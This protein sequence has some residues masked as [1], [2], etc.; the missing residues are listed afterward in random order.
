M[1][2]RSIADFIGSLLG[3]VCFV[4]AINIVIVPHGLYSGTLTGVAQIIESLVITHT[5]LTMPQGINLTGIFLLI[6]N[7]PLMAMVQ[8][9]TQTGFP[10]KS[11]INIIFL[12]IVMAF[13][14][15]PAAPVL[16]DTLTASIVGGALAGFGAGF[17][18]RCGGSGG[19]S[20]LIGVYCSVKYPNF[21]VGRVT[22]IISIFVYGYGL[23]A[24]D[25][26]IVI[27][28]AIF[29]TLYAFSLD[30]AHSQNIKTSALIF[31]A[32][33]VAV[34]GVLQE[35][36]RGA[37]CWEGKGAYSGKHTHIFNTV[38]SKYEIPRL[39]QIIKE[40][41]PSAFIVFNNNVGVAGNFVKKL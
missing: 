17:M 11:I 10:I 4:I 16:H 23:L 33:P 13:I 34:Q 5:A 1:K 24:H 12:T 36:Q 35:L 25:L 7:I 6:I 3:A 18:L 19:G 29:T 26:N 27:Y 2:L 30:R 20:D 21:T 14:P 41:D 40:A 9:V 31:T 38:I 22:L 39:K 28:S 32:S 15:I 8:R 37:T